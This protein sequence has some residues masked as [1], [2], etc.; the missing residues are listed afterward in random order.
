MAKTVLLTG[1]TGFLGS[2]LAHT[3]AKEGYNL[4]LLKR[5]TSDIWRIHDL[6]SKV[7][8]CFDADCVDDWSRPFCEYGKVDA[9]IHTATNYG[10]GDESIYSVQEANVNFPLRL[11]EV[12]IKHGVRC[13]LNTD[14]FFQK[15]RLSN[16]YMGSYSL[17]KRHFYDWGEFFAENEKVCFANLRLEHVYGP[18]DGKNKFIPFV[19]SSCI[20]NVPCLKLTEGMQRR[21]FVYVNDVVS[22]F[23]TV[24]ADCLNH[25]EP[26]LRNY[27]VGTGKSMP[28]RTFIEAIAEVTGTKTILDFGAIPMHSNEIL[29]SHANTES[30]K[31]IGWRPKY[32]DIYKGIRTMVR[33]DEMMMS[34]IKKSGGVERNIIT[35]CLLERR[36]SA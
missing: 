6:L 30:L 31:D 13:F 3:L 9:I 23:Q 4:I 5:S 15:N 10:R 11:L 7:K 29:D 27:E 20:D 22:A 32:T 14:S 28:I 33:E 2:H 12:G 24:L 1:A 36:Q 17:T 26:E 8:G 35:I 18:N 21:D 16:A 19:L 25:P 34:I